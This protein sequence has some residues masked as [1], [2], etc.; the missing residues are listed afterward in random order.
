MG[1]MT[2]DAHTKVLGIIGTPVEHSKSPQMHAEFARLTGINCVYTAFDV[3]TDRLADAIYGVRGLGIK[4][5]NI[6]APHKLDVIEY[7]DEISEYARLFGSVNTVVNRE[8]KLVGYNTDAEGFY[9]SILREGIDIVDKDVLIFGAGG[10]TQPIV[11]LFA[12][13][14]AKSITVINRTEA[15]ANKLKDY[16]KLAVGYD[17]NTKMQL[18]HYDVVINTTTAGM[19]PQT[20]VLP[21][22]DLGFIDSDTAVVDMIYNPWQT[23][24][25]KQAELRGAK[26]VNG[27]GMLIYQGILAYELFTDTKLPENAFELAKKAVLGK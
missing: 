3:T 1:R 16:V 6:T 9:K 21:Y 23:E 14:G 10:A 4:G 2:V 20:G 25:L 26:T 12:M 11:V 8:G 5:V 27:L 13:R 7:L 24:F 19:A 17:I 22:E 15:R 18:S